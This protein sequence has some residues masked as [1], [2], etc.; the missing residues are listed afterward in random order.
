M[1][2]MVIIVSGSHDF[3]KVGKANRVRFLAWRI[4]ARIAICNISGTAMAGRNR[5]FIKLVSIFIYTPNDADKRQ[6]K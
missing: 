5:S 1:E 4:P 2:S 6:A 3:S